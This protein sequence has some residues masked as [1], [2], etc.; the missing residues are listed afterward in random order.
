MA[1]AIIIDYIFL[2]GPNRNWISHRYRNQYQNPQWNPVAVL[3]LVP[4]LVPGSVTGL[5]S[6]PGSV[7]YTRICHRNWYW[8]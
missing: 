2:L 1:I 4:E 8:Y 5:E 7:A 6:V 3:E